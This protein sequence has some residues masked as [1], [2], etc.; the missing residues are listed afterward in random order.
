MDSLILSKAVSYILRHAPWEYE[1]E[2]DDEGWVR[3]EDLLAGLRTEPKFV[4]ITTKD[5][6]LMIEQSD[7]KRHEL[8]DERIRALYGHSL[9]G[10]LVRERAVPPDILYHGSLRGFLD[11]ILRLGLRPMNRQYVHLSVDV[12][13][14]KVVAARKGQDIMLLEIPARRMYDAGVPFYQGNEKVW[15]ADAIPKEWLTLVP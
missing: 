14:A 6:V 11:S 12:V 8:K 2:L 9:P 15:L 4:S 7:K 3:L 5:L 1:L 10:K 13:T